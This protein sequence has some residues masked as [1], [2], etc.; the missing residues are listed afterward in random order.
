M[1]EY[2]QIE[3]FKSIKQATLPSTNLNLYFGLNSMGKSSVL[4]TL[5]L[6]RQSF[7]ANNKQGIRGLNTNGPLISLGTYKDVFC[8]MAETDILRIYIRNSDDSIKDFIFEHDNNQ[9]SPL[10]YMMR[11][12]SLDEERYKEPLFSE[13]FFYLGA[14]HLG[15]QKSYTTENWFHNGINELG[16]N[17]VYAIPFLASQGEEIKVPAELCLDDSR[18]NSLIDQVTAWM[19]LISPGIHI[20]TELSAYEERARLNISYGAKQLMTGEYTP[21]NV[22]FGISYVLP[23]IIELLISDKDSLL[24]IE[25]PESHLHPKGQTALA[26][27]IAKASSNGAQIFC[28]S[29]SDHIINGIRVAVK[30][31]ILDNNDLTILYFSKND[32]QETQIEFIETD[33]NGNLN[34]YPDGLLD[35]WGILMAEL[36]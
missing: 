21:V 35:E 6:L 7:F 25:N 23:L 34:N 10:D 29:H 9:V 24:L 22:G 32:N 17:G 30:K 26:T 28:E 2:I 11:I 12:E 13:K 19:K 14:E 36:I 1:I 4:Q 33:K 15:P 8:E 5:L 16:N 18:S 31:Q 27:L 3:N 20:R